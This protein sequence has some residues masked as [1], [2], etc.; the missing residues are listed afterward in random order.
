ML[1]PVLRSTDGGETWTFLGL[2]GPR[3]IGRVGLGPAD[4][5][6]AFVAAVGNLWAENAERGVFKTTDGGRTWTKVLYV[7]PFSGATD[8][9]MDPRDAKVLYAATYQRLRKTFGFN[10]GGPGSAI[11][12]STDAGVTWKKLEHGIPAGDKGRIGLALARSQTDV[13]VATIEH[14]TAGGTYRTEDAGVTW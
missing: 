6:V 13:L 10:G 4:G 11:Y 9:V 3:A 12:K 5:N 8:L 2:H 1:R 7:D 14:P